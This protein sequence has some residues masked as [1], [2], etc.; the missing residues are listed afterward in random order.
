MAF[1]RARWRR[2]Q[3]C[4]ENALKLECTLQAHGIPASKVATSTDMQR[5]PQLRSRE[6]WVEVEDPKLGKIVIERSAYTLS[7]TPSK[8]ERSAPALGADNTYVLENML[9]YSRS[10]INRLTASGV[11]Q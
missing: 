11:L 1:R 7:R 3:T 5:D 2:A 10:R 8:V 4:S 9:G 6:H